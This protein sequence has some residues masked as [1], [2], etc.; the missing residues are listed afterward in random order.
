MEKA[1]VLHSHWP[2][3]GERLVMDT[4]SSRTNRDPS[5]PCWQRRESNPVE[6]S[7]MLEVRVSFARDTTMAGCGDFHSTTVGSKLGDSGW[8]A[9][10]RCSLL[11][12]GF[13]C[14]V[15][16]FG[17]LECLG[18]AAPS[19]KWPF[20]WGLLGASPCIFCLASYFACL[21]ALGNESQTS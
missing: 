15:S 4:S 7:G 5:E 21:G 12:G 16:C 17:L 6:F 13:R 1:T 3:D 18:L 10:S 14:L 2:L 9:C 11:A 20:P 8:L 19:G